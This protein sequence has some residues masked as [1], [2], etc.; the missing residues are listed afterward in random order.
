MVQVGPFHDPKS[1]KLVGLLVTSIEPGSKVDVENL[2]QSGDVVVEINQRV[3]FDLDP[4]V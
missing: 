1:G 4:D 3:L 2:L